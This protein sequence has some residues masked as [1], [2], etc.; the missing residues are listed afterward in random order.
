M[1]YNS[2]VLLNAF[3]FLVYGIS[4]LSTTKMKDE[5]KRFGIPQFRI[6][7][8]LLQVFG[9][10]GCI[11]GYV[12]LDE[13]LF[14]SAAGLSILMFSGLIVRLKIK[15]PFFAAMPAI[16]FFILNLIIAYKTLILF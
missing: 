3:A 13:L 4:C 5:F 10:I 8:G 1:I 2:I 9:G 15:D 6:L 14:L 11:I 16:T 12:W 7:T